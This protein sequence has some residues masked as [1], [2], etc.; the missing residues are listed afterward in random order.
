MQIVFSCPPLLRKKLDFYIKKSILWYHRRNISLID[1]ELDKFM[2]PDLGTSPLYITSKPEENS[3]NIGGHVIVL[4]AINTDATG[5]GIVTYLDPF[6]KTRNGS[7]RRYVKY[8]LLLDSMA[9]SG[10]TL[11]DGRNRV[12]YY[13]AFSIGLK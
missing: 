8:S 9:E 7:N 11:I 1:N 12:N 5:D 2:N 4:I 3:S 10:T 6:A 13:D